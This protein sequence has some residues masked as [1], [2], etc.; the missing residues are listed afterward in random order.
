[1][2]DSFP[3]LSRSF[4]ILGALSAPLPFSGVEAQVR[5]SGIV[6]DSATQAPLEL[7]E[8]STDRAGVTAVTDAAGRFALLLPEG[9]HLLRL[10]RI[11]YAPLSRVIR[12]TPADTSLVLLAMVAEARELAPVVI[13]GQRNRTWPPGFDQR[14]R[15]GFGKFVDDS[16]LRTFEHTSLASAIQARIPNVTITRINGRA[17]AMARRS[18][19]MAGGGRC[20]LAIWLDGVKIFPTG[21][22]PPDLDRFSVMNLTAVEV[23]TTAQ[24]PSQ[25]RTTGGAEC[26]VMLLWQKGR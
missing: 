2:P 26:G 4:L 13:E 24:V 17:V 16:T 21:A 8:V 14:V 1:M 10:R 12:V 18:G 6:R 22:P 20:P 23:Y 3:L 11:G 19:T 15:E 5:V 9:S 7:V 25:Y